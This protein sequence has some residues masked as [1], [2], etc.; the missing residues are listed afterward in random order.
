MSGTTARA[1][2]DDLRQRRIMDEAAVNRLLQRERSPWYVVLLSGLAA[3]LAAL[4]LFGSTLFTLIDDSALA[5]GIAGSLLLGVAVGLLRQSGIFVSQLGLA[6]SLLGQGLL[7]LAISRQDMIS[8]P[9]ER[10]PALAAALIAILLWLAPGIT[11]HRL[12][13]ALIAA[14]AGAVL[15]GH[16]GFL[17]LYGVF[18]AALAVC[19]WLRRSR[20]ARGRHAAL[21]R[22]LAG[23]ATLAGLVLPII[24]HQRWSGAIEGIAG[25][26]GWVSPAAAA[27]L[28]LI[29]GMTLVRAQPAAQ[30]LTVAAAL[31]LLVALG[32]TAPGLLIAAALWLAVFH[33]CERLWS[34][35]VG[36]AATLYLG[37]FYYSLHITLLEKSLLLMISGA[38]LLL[39]RWYLQRHGRT[40][41]E[42]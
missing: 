38:V 34:L 24:I 13:C 2:A 33:A 27:A 17:P 23:A 40:I 20:W 7:L 36:L 31:L 6:L 4:L 39:L 25:I 32:G 30:R 9:G 18:V 26:P 10:L 22:S 8:L 11:L 14:G 19:F 12:T 37:D 1:L 5:A 15:V 29:T 41:H 28:L 21:W 42:S 3:W 16:N 35:V